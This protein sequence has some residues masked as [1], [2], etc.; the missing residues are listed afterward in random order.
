M[1]VTCEDIIR[2]HGLTP[3]R[4][5]N[6]KDFLDT[7][8]V[9]ANL[10]MTTP[11]Q[12]MWTDDKEFLK[13]YQDAVDRDEKVQM[14]TKTWVFMCFIGEV[15]LYLANKE[16]ICHIL[17]V[18]LGKHGRKDTSTCAI[19]FDEGIDSAYKQGYMCETCVTPICVKCVE[20]CIENRIHKCGV[21]NTMMN[22]IQL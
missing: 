19:C 7:M 2:K 6:G 5:R 4:F 3:K 16:T 21:C 8:I 11:N 1:G 10:A 17:N 18:Y 13:L 15:F 12:V 20:K 22:I 9:V 14:K